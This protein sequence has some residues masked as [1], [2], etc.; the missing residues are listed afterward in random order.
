[1]TAYNSTRGQLKCIFVRFCFATF[2]TA[3]PAILTGRLGSITGNIGEW[4]QACN[5]YKETL[6]LK[7]RA[8]G[9]QHEEIIKTLDLLAMTLIEQS[10]FMDAAKPVK[11]AL[12]LRRKRFGN[13][14]PEVVSQ[15]NALAFLYKKAGDEARAKEVLSEISPQQ[16][17]GAVKDM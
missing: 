8:Y 10:R 16:E 4:E 7:K 2:V 17:A 15:I 3:T 12:D 6:I 11:E 1:M 5:A 14:H 13:E 9:G